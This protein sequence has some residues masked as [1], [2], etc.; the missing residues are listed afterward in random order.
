VIERVKLGPRMNAGL[1]AAE[2]EWHAFARKT[3]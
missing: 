2:L 1:R 3:G